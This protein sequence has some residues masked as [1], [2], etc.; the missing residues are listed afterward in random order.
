VER[1]AVQDIRLIA[2]HPNWHE[3]RVNRLLFEQARA[4]PRVDW[5]D[6]YAS[7]PDYAIDVDRE[8][9][10]LAGK[11]LLV[12]LHPVHWYAMPALAKLWVDE[13]LSYGWA[14]GQG[15]DALRGMDCWLVAS[16]G[17]PA[18]SYQPEG[19][20]R[21]AF[22]AFLPPYVQTANLC[23]MRFLPPLLIHGAHRISDAQL[24]SQVG[25]FTERLTHYPDW[26]DLDACRLARP[27]D[28]PAVDRLPDPPP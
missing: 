19:Y 24:A 25:R 27:A 14:Y 9:A 13:V 21:F 18:D 22:E 15:G 4:L 7:Y 10:A 11:R 17:G 5:L 8:Q 20:N 12:L 6:L 26:P 28:V 23:G 1:A 16:T 2:A 3:S